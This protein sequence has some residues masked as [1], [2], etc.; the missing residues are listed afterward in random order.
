VKLEIQENAVAERRDLLH[1]FRAGTGEKL[2]A[3]FEHSDQ[4]GNATRKLQRSGKRIE[5]QSDN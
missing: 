3:D 1:C 2:V 4:V 5:V